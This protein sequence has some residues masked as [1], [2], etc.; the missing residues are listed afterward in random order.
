MVDIG[1]L[2][3]EI[4][5]ALSPLGYP[6]YLQ[7]TISD[8]PQSYFAFFIYATDT[9]A[10]YDNA[11]TYFVPNVTIMFFSTDATL[12]ATLPQQARAALKENGYVPQGIGN[13]VLS[14][15][16]AFTGWAQDYAKIL[17]NTEV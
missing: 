11:E 15:D 7:G 6:V 4:I 8:A 3:D 14:D 9:G 1:A 2:K 16:P 5:N 10:C 13:D 12:V 17:T